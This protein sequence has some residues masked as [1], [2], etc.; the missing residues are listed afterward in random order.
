M[1]RDVGVTAGWQRLR[2]VLRSLKARLTATVIAMLTVAILSVGGLSQYRVEHNLLLQTEEREL[3]LTVHMA[4]EMAQRSVLLQQLLRATA[5]QWPAGL[6]D[7]DAALEQRLLAQPML[8]QEFANLFV[9]GPDGQVRLFVDEAGVRRPKV[10]I[11]DRPYF[12]QVM[13]EARPVISG[14]VPGRLSAE[15]VVVFTHPILERGQVVAV[16]GGALRLSSRSLASFVLSDS[17]AADE[18]LVV[19]DEHGIVL[20]HPSRDR[21]LH[22]LSQDPELAEAVADWTA[23]GAPVEPSGL[24]LSQTGLV[25]TAAGVAGTGWMVWRSMPESALLEPLRAIRLQTLWDGA[26]LI[27]L[28][29]VLA[30]LVTRWQ[31]VPLKQLQE[32]A[33]HLFN[34]ELDIHDGWP[35]SAGEVDSIVQVLRHVGAERAQLE[36]FSHQLINKLNSV[37]AAAPLGIAFT[38]ERRFELVSH[39]WCRLLQREEHELLGTE[40][41]HIFASDDDYAALGTAVSRAFAE[42]GE[43]AGEWRIRRRDGT[44]FWAGV[45]GRPVDRAHPDA[46]TIWTLTDVTESR[47]S[48][49]SLEWSATHDPL[50]G[51]ANRQAFDRRLEALIGHPPSALLMLDLDH[52][53]PIN[54]RHG[55]AAGDAMLHAVADALQHQVRAGDLVARLGGDEFGVLLAGCPPEAAQRVAYQLE[56][57]VA[58]IR[59]DWEGQILQVGVS[60]GLA[61][62]S[63]SLSTREA[64]CAA[65]DAACYA[66]KASGRR[67]VRVASVGGPAPV[68]ADASLSPT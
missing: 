17:D 9:A 35:R 45:Q 63:D 25:V 44:V 16:F 26:G 53:K 54:D 64:W 36:T 38:R 41:R 3:H 1:A 19:T 62:A 49:E 43:Y 66:A 20:S 14:A 2:Q 8:L 12:Q 48:R 34:T 31:L 52:F 65:A 46:G 50:T 22:P 56:R 28:L 61:A 21:L 47:A 33:R 57:A 40:A 29:G 4:E 60:V 68:A 32:R 24:V 27:L 51:L 15:P 55:H 18:R 58:D 37:M 59:L 10:S 6:V 67:T 5:A 23:R 11:A 42:L 7:Q 13:A 30:F 39:A